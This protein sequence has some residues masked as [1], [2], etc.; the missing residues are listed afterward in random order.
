MAHGAQTT[1]LALPSRDALEIPPRSRQEY[2]RMLTT[3]TARGFYR[4]KDTPLYVVA[5]S[6]LVAF[7][8]RADKAREEMFAKPDEFLEHA[9]VC[10]T[11]LVVPDM[12]RV[13]AVDYRTGS[14]RWELTF[15]TP[16]LI[17]SLGVTSGVLHVVVRHYTLCRATAL[18]SVWVAT[19]RLH[20]P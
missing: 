3:R 16:R 2:L 5:G 9:L 10:G 11:T 20:V 4:P 6:E 12:E 14:K 19:S 1:T 17:E 13:F 18:G 7:D 15:D 8:L